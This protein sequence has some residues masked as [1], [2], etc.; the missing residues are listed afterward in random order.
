MKYNH[1][2]LYHAKPSYDATPPRIR[3]E[4]QRK[5]TA[6]TFANAGECCLLHVTLL[7]RHMKQL[8]LSIFMLSWSLGVSAVPLEEKPVVTIKANITEDTLLSSS[9][10]YVIDEEVHVRSGVTLTAE[11][12]TTILIKNGI[13]RQYEYGKS[14]RNILV[15]DPGSSLIAGNLYF[16]ACDTH[17]RPEKKADNGG[18]IFLGSSSETVRKN[19]LIVNM[20][21]TPSSF[22][23]RHIHAYYTGA[24]DLPQPAPIAR[25]DDYDGLSLIGLNSNEWRVDSITIKYPGDDGFDTEDSEIKI[26]N[27]QVIAPTYEDGINMTNSRL[28]ILKTLTLDVGITGIRDRDLFDFEVDRN[29]TIIRVANGVKVSLNGIFGDQVFMVSDDLPPIDIGLY[30]FFGITTKGQS[31]IFSMNKD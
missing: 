30:T 23:A 6:S 29:P 27:L 26:N 10:V 13:F 21:T 5:P 1:Q 4:H 19:Y 17:N 12:D 14:P 11:N 9:N 31:Y 24:T 18:I 25:V 2:P 7:K 15:F 8:I 28:D 22:R 3:H 16:R 20:S